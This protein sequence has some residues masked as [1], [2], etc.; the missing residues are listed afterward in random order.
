VN[1]YDPADDI[2]YV[3]LSPEVID[4]PDYPRAGQMGPCS[5]LG[6]LATSHGGLPRDGARRT[7]SKGNR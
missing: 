4:I 7:A 6:P 1:T 2:V 3:H 5:K